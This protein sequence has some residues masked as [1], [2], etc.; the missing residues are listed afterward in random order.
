VGS[1]VLSGLLHRFVEQ[2]GIQFGK[3]LLGGRSPAVPTGSIR[4]AG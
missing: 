2:P 3:R 4:R 1:F